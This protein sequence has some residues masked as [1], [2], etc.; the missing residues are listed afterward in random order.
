MGTL[1][2]SVWRMLKNVEI[3]VCSH[4]IVSGLLPLKLFFEKRETVTN[5]DNNR[6]GGKYNQASD[7]T[8]NNDETKQIMYFFFLRIW[9]LTL[10]P[11]LIDPSWQLCPNDASMTSRKRAAKGDVFVNKLPITLLVNN[12]YFSADKSPFL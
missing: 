12:C 8:W 10:V 9:I 3:L 1:E 5:D 6:I 11:I 7:N 4:K 2:T